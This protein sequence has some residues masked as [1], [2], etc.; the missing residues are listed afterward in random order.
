MTVLREPKDAAI[1]MRLV[2]HPNAV[3]PGRNTWQGVVDEIGS[4]I[5]IQGDPNS[6]AGIRIVLQAGRRAD[7]RAV[8]A[9]L[10]GASR[11]LGLGDA[12]ARGSAAQEAGRRSRGPVPHGR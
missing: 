10:Q 4:A 11:R 3:G 7:A 6:T 12:A 8:Q 5:G 2:V 1:R 9:R